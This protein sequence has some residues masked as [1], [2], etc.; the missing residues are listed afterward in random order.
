MVDGKAIREELEF[1]RTAPLNLEGQ[2][3]LVIELT[4]GQ[5]LGMWDHMA[6]AEATGDITNAYLDVVKCGLCT[7]DGI[8]V[9]DDPREVARLPAR[10][11]IPTA[12]KILELSE[13]TLELPG[14]P[15]QGPGET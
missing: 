9:Y 6:E 13:I 8:P 2:D 1:R 11:M 14:N 5:M 3:L 15:P 4:A 10:I 12:E 7:P